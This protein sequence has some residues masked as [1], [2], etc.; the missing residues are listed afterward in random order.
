MYQLYRNNFIA[1]IIV[2]ANVLIIFFYEG[3]FSLGK[4]EIINRWR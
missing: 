1:I 2:E 3:M 4:L